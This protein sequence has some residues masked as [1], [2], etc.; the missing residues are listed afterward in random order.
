MTLLINTKIVD[1][2]QTRTV[3][4]LVFMLFSKQCLRQRF[5]AYSFWHRMLF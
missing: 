4:I 1:N 3:S 5:V 2:P